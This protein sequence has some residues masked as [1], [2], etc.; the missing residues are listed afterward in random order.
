MFNRFTALTALVLF[1]GL[2]FSASAQNQ[3][4]TGTGGKGDS[5]TIYAPAAT[6]LE[7]DKSY[8]PALVQGEF[9]S[10]F[11][12]YSDIYVVDWER[13]DDIYLKLFEGKYDDNAEARQDLGRL[14]PTACFMSGNITKTASGYNLQMNITKT[15]NKRTI[16]SFSRTFAFSELDNLSGIRKASLEL[17]KKMG[18][19]LTAQAQEELAG[20]AVESRVS[21]QT[22]L[23]KGGTAQRENSEVAALSYYFQA[24]A[25]DPSL[26]EAVSRSSKL[27]ANITSGSMGDNIRNDIQWRKAWIER[28]AETERFLDDLNKAG[29][30]PY[31]LYYS[32]D[33]KQGTVN[34]Q[35]ETVNLSIS[36]Y[37]VA[38]GRARSTERALEAVYDGLEATQR[39]TAWQL[40]YWPWQGVTE[41]N[42]LPGYRQSF[43]VVF[44]LLNDK[45][46]VIGRQTLQAG[47]L[48]SSGYNIFSPLRATMDFENVN[49]NDITDKM[50]IRAVSV[51]GTD[52][53]AAA[54]NGVLQ[55]IVF[56]KAVAAG[57][58]L[59]DSRD[60]KSYRTIK[61]A[62]QTWMAE[63]LNY[64]TEGSACYGNNAS[65]CA[66]Y[67]ALYNWDDATGA[68]PAGW[69]LPANSDWYNLVRLTGMSGRD[70]FAGKTLKSASGWENPTGNGTDD[71]GFSALP[72]GRGEGNRFYKGKS[73]GFWWS[74]TEYS[75]DKA[76]GRCM[77]D[78]YNEVARRDFDKKTNFFS[79]RCMRDN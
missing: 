60:G 68:C 63:N 78:Y 43:S 40:R 15:A 74:A 58:A 73:G 22:A 19:T 34:Y 30:M 18:V 8:I 72:G 1:T 31:T 65:N 10:N 75:A 29:P 54:K 21:A 67:G 3:K 37:L 38:N 32:D 76:V 6:G 4:W 20:A 28:L 71:F 52:A 35:T 79:V 7:A 25:F 27:N 62:H 57:A 45:N 26:M 17:L 49:A 56:T 24:A 39:R 50:T 41:L 9:V 51:N 46:K 23:A 16:A 47:G 55:I 69:R 48:K 66:K 77:D 64:Q 36:T 12:N 70:H 5:I 61:I 59:K 44:E 13:L 11:S 33:I 53:A 2:A 14:T 42:V